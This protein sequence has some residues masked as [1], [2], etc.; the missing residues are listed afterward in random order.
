M[1]TTI[2]PSTFRR[3]SERT[4]EADAQAA[5]EALRLAKLDASDPQ[6]FDWEDNCRERCSL[7]FAVSGARSAGLVGPLEGD[8]K[9]ELLFDAIEAD[10]VDFYARYER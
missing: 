7:S 4:G 9:R 8:E 3:S 10:D 1:V 6:G 2:K 5:H